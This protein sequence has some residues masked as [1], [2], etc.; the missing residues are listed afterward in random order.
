M[1]NNI[2]INIAIITLSTYTWFFSDV[3]GITDDK[4]IDR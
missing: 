1:N 2:Q 4:Y 3:S